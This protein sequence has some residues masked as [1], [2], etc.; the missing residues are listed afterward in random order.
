MNIN[1][2]IFCNQLCKYDIQLHSSPIVVNIKLS[3]R[4]MKILFL[5][6]MLF[7]TSNAG[8]NDSK[9][10]LPKFFNCITENFTTISICRRL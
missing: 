10:I 6:M 2:G 9:L 4:E 7:I 1:S 8:K 3:S 5:C